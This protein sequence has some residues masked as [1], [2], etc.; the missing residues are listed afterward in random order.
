[1]E[2]VNMKHN[3]RTAMLFRVLYP[4]SHA[5]GVF[6]LF[7]GPVWLG[8]SKATDN[9]IWEATGEALLHMQD[10]MDHEAREHP[11]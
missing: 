4:S 3:I 8:T 7:N 6:S 9:A 10:Q 1:M 5:K 2:R 11:Q